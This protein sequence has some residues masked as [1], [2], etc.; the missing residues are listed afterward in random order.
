MGF[1][2]Q[3]V[4]GEEFTLITDAYKAYPMMPHRVVHPGEGYLDSDDPIL[5]THTLEGFYS[6]LKP[7]GYGSH[8]PYTK[9][10]SV[11]IIFR[12]VG[13]LT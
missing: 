10:E 3:P 9:G 4:E 12:I 5:H 2:E 13:R 6:L 7:A 8:P 1:I 11:L